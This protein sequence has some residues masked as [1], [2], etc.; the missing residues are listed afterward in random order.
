M[1]RDTV[2]HQRIMD[3]QATDET[4]STVIGPAI[5]SKYQYHTFHV[6]FGTGV[7]AGVVTIETA[8]DPAYTGTWAS[9][10]DVTFAGTAPNQLV[11]VE[12]GPYLALRARISTAIADGT[13]TVDYVAN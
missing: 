12:T 2:F 9:L 5:A 6:S 4:V 11:S 1:A 8:N 10:G 7:S 13:V 3:A